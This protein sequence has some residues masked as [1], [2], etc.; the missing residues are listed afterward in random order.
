MAWW[1]VD[2]DTEQGPQSFVVD[3]PDVAAAVLRARNELGDR[4]GARPFDLRGVSRVDVL[5]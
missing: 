3:G 4:L 2:V 5:V 1:Q